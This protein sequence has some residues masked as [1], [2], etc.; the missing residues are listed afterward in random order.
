MHVKAP[1]WYYEVES[2]GVKLAGCCPDTRQMAHHRLL[3]TCWQEGKVAVQLPHSSSL[4]FVM[5]DSGNNLLLG[6]DNGSLASFSLSSLPAA[7]Q[8]Q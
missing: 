5:A 6:Q 8:L 2:C 7:G 4:P 1:S 3:A